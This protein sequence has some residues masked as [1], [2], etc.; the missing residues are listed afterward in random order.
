MEKT[1]FISVEGIDGSGTTTVVE[2][3]ETRLEDEYTVATTCEPTDTPIGESVRDVIDSDSDTHPLTD[4]H[5]FIGDRMH[6][7]NTIINPRLNDSTTDI[8]LTDRYADSTL[9][10]QP[11]VFEKH[12]IMSIESA[13]QYINRMIVQAIPIPDCTLLLDVDY[14][15]AYNR[16][17]YTDADKYETSKEFQ[18][19]VSERYRRLCN[20]QETVTQID[21]NNSI[22]TV[23]DTCMTEIETLISE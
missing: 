1:L 18:K 15:T 12:D 7:V 16:L 10:Y 21:A 19:R 14:E 8:I 6:N 2:T 23:V 5:F 22:K 20:Q 4:L 17:S 11:I 3:L 9:V 13:E